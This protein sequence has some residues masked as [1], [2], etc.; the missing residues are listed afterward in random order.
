MALLTDVGT[1]LAAATVSTADLTLGTNLFLGREPASPDTCVT[2][3][4]PG[5]AAPDDPVG[6]NTA[7]SLENPGLQVRSRAAAYSTAQSLAVDVWALLAKVINETLTS[8]TYL[9]IS[10]VQSPFALDRDDQDRMIFVCNFDV[11]KVP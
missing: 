8:T 4:E 11:V 7:P 9:K 10:P 3:Y 1:Y 5:G 2:L 6:G